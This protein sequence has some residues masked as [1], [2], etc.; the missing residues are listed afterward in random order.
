MIQL[1]RN[2]VPYEFVLFLRTVIKCIVHRIGSLWNAIIPMLIYY[3]GFAETTTSSQVVYYE[4]VIDVASGFRDAYPDS[5]VLITRHSLG[6]G[7][8]MIA[9]KAAPVLLH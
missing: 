4:D 6:G 7:V 1:I 9:G 8:A 2:V 5:L 3:M